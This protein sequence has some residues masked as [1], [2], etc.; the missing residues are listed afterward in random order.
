MNDRYVVMTTRGEPAIRTSSA[1][2]AARYRARLGGTIID[3]E[4]ER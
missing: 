3:R 2:E 1:E 4:A